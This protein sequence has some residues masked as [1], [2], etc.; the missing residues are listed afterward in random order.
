MKT[1]NFMAKYIQLY[2]QISMNYPTLM[3]ISNCVND[4]ANYFSGLVLSVNF[5][6]AYFLVEF[7]SR[8]ILKDKIYV[9]GFGVIVIELDYI[10]MVDIFHNVNFPLKCYLLLFIHLLPRFNEKKLL[11]Y[12]DCNHLPCLLFS[13]TDHLCVTP[14][15]LV[16]H[17]SPKVSL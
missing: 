4:G 2:F 6:I 13:P 15:K 8:K 14:S 12:F 17:Y 7:S 5:F 9:F 11:D 3:Q 16:L 1:H 10:W